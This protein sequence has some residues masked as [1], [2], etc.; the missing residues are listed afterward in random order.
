LCC[1]TFAV[2]A[3]SLL[4]A[5]ESVAQQGGFFS[6]SLFDYH[7]KECV[8]KGWSKRTIDVGGHTR[9]LFW[10]GPPGYWPLGAIVILHP[11][12]GSYSNFCS[13]INHGRPMVEFADAAIG[14][15][16]A[17]FSLD[18]LENKFLGAK[19]KPCG[20]RFDS[21]GNHT[22]T[23][24]DLPFI[25][26]MLNK[27]IPQFRP[28]GSKRDIF[29][30]GISNGGFM[31]VMA[32]ANYPDLIS[33][34]AVVSAGDPYGTH[35]DCSQNPLRQRSTPGV[36][37]DNE[38][39]K[40]LSDENACKAAAYRKEFRW[41]EPKLRYNPPFKLFYHEG[42]PII[43]TSCKEKLHRILVSNSFEDAG[44]FILPLRGWNR[45]ANHAW[46]EDYNQPMLDF[47]VAQ[48]RPATTRAREMIHK[49]K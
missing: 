46:L 8:R 15:G 42:D 28:T 19:G 30:A 48:T 47:F 39:G 37:I 24:A 1:L 18:S 33:G 2:A 3:F 40:P 9:K 43:N 11:G 17:L 34:F 29:L 13:N 32:A 5:V 49:D 21:V 35:L 12:G 22:S 4:I 16:F 31:T 20:K 14:Q 36:L 27:V 23:N 45:Q 6:D 38:T 44:S 25:E 41:P 7:E 26:I 10:R